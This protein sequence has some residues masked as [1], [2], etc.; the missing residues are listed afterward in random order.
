MRSRDPAR[1]RNASSTVVGISER[2]PSTDSGASTSS[3]SAASA[4]RTRSGIA[5]VTLTRGRDTDASVLVPG[6]RPRHRVPAPERGRGD[7]RAADPAGDGRQ[8]GAVELA[9]EHTL[10]GLREAEREPRV[11]LPVAQRRRGRQRLAVVGL[12]QARVAPAEVTER[13]EEPRVAEERRLL[14]ALR[15]DE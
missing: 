10:P 14:E 9:G 11:D 15:R 6:E 8:L 12:H 1:A 3:K 5:P 7:A 2:M 13:A 4:S